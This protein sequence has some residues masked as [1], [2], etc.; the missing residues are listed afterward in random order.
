[1]DTTAPLPPLMILAVED[2]PA[3][4]AAIR[5][6]LTAHALTYDLQVIE[7]ADHALHFFDQLPL[8]SPRR[9]PDIVLLDLHLPQRHGTD[10]LRH[11]KTLPACAAIRVVMMTS[12][13]DP[14]DRT[15][16]LALGADVFFEKPSR[17]T[18]FMQLGAIIKALACGHPSEGIAP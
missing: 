10:V 4:V 3:D 13:V 2:N 16:T 14:A 12:S 11:L 7:N 17:L 1:M 9:C 8:P 15:E 18:E 5:R 6:V